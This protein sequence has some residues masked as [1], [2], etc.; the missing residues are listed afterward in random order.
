MKAK[1][2]DKSSLIELRE[3][4]RLCLEELKK[5]ILEGKIE[6]LPNTSS[7]VNASNKRVFNMA[8][9]PQKQDS[10]LN[11]SQQQNQSKGDLDTAAPSGKRPEGASSQHAIL[12]PALTSQIKKYMERKK[13]KLP[14]TL[15]Q[16]AHQE[17]RLKIQENLEQ[18]FKGIKTKQA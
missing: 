5:E 9:I 10:K 12:N 7:A 3:L 14:K 18:L 17:K 11:S 2:K 1:R 16:T 8:T 4:K 15:E 13:G 6:S